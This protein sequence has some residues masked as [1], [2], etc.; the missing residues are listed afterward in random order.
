MD[1]KWDKKVA[2]R[3]FL[4]VSALT[5]AMLLGPGIPFITRRAHAQGVW[6]S[7]GRCIR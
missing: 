7:T 2:R 5:G 1:K 4:K 6:S 3:D